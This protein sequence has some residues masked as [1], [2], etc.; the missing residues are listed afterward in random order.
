MEI[1][2][3]KEAYA[4]K[5]LLINRGMDSSN[6]KVLEMGDLKSLEDANKDSSAMFSN[7]VEIRIN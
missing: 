2:G 7:R 5:K 1:M 6:L 4:I 3:L